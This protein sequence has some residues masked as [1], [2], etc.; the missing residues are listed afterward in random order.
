MARYQ[1]SKSK[2][3]AVFNRDSFTCLYCGDFAPRVT[4]H[5]D[6]IKAVANGGTNEFSNLVTAC[7]DCNIGKGVKSIKRHPALGVTPYKKTPKLADDLLIPF[8]CESYPEPEPLRIDSLPGGLES[9]LLSYMDEKDI[10]GNASDDSDWSDERLADA[11]RQFE[12]QFE[13]GEDELCQ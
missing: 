5:V 2:R 12:A 13:Y 1:I 10:R 3:F 8:A 11:A 6:H 7:A 4:L 9:W